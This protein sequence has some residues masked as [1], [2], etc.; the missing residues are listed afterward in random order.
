VAGRRRPPQG[1]TKR[2]SALAAENERLQRE[3]EWRIEQLERERD[4]IATVVDSTST[5]F[6]VLDSDGAIVRLNKPL[7]RLAGRTGDEVRG[8]PF[9]DVFVV[10]KEASDFRR[11]LAADDGVEHESAFCAADGSTAIV[12]WSRSTISGEDGRPQILFSGIDVTQRKRER[13]QLLASRAR[14]VEAAD[15]ARRRIERDLHDGAQQRLV[16]LSLA[17][18]LAAQ[19]LAAGR[20]KAAAKDIARVEEE[21]AIALEELRELARGIHPAV[22]SERG[23]PEALEMLAVRSPVPVEVEQ[24]PRE[25]LPEH[26]EAAIYYV[27]SEALTNVAKYSRARVAS[28]RVFREDGYV[29]T[30][31]EDDGVGGADANGGSGLRGLAD[32]VEALEGTLSIVSPRGGPT[33][34]RATVREPV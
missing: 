1:T 30:E 12:A 6:C 25:R 19:N 32:R 21:L 2:A 15:T 18:R 24:A 22:L 16:A 5:L 29:V 8:R 34:L 31:V 28:V 27:V 13:E 10:R 3:L 4:F 7:G 26:L 9:W 14:I 23:L 20:A 17:V 33:L 11:R